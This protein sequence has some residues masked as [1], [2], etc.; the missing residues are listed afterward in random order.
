[1]ALP[2]LVSEGVAHG[3]SP[4][5]V[6]SAVPVLIGR[7]LSLFLD[8]A[9]GGKFPSGVVEHGVNCHTDPMFVTLVHEIC[10]IFICPQSPVHQAQIPG[11]IAVAC[12]FKDR[13]DIKGGAA[14]IPYVG[15]PLEQ[16]IKTTGCGGFMICLRSSQ[17]PQ[18]VDVIKNCFLI[19]GLHSRSDLL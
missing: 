1:M 6:Y 13:T 15:D 10:K 7:G 2:C 9:E 14:Q 16:L 4:A 5:E 18:R 8:I 11:V 12:G 17:E 3:A 19:P